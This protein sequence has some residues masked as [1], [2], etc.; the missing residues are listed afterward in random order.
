MFN[1]LRLVEMLLLGLGLVQTDSRVAY[2][3]QWFLLEYL[4]FITLPL[5]VQQDVPQV[6]QL[7]YQLLL[8]RFV[9]LETMDL[10]VSVNPLP[11]QKVE[12]MLLPGLGQVQMDL[13]VQ[14]RIQLFQTQ[15]PE[16]ILLLLP[17]QVVANLPAIQL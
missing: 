4:V 14:I 3:R 9:V 8:A 13:R 1:F 2:K 15:A 7:L 10:F 17:I 16:F 6:V 11:L 5:Q 12:T